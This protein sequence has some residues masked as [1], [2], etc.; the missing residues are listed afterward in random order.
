MTK[1]LKN[2]KEMVKA[3]NSHR[4]FTQL[5]ESQQDC[6]KRAHLTKEIIKEEYADYKDDRPSSRIK[7]CFYI[8]LTAGLCLWGGLVG[9]LITTLY[10]KGGIV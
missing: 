10:T 6:V 1:N 4:E 9:L 8:L 2:H 7:A 5:L 3:I